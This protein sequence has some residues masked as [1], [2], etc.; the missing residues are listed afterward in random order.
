MDWTQYLFRFE[1]RIARTSFWFGLLYLLCAMMLVIVL[2]AIL[3]L[4][5]TGD[6]S[7]N[8]DIDDIFMIVDPAAYRLAS[9]AKLP[10]AVFKLGGTALLLWVYLALSIKRLHDRDRGAWWIVPFFVLP[11]LYN[12]FEDRLPNSYW[13]LPVVLAACVLSLWGLIEMGFLR[14]SPHANRFGPDPVEK[15][16]ARQRSGATSA[17]HADGWDQQSALELVPHGASPPD[18]MHVKRGI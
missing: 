11:G 3:G 10:L 14:G 4:L 6:G 1:G 15:V 5:T 7:F 12:Q 9:L 18:G 13:I 2:G 17:P 16:Q 8:L